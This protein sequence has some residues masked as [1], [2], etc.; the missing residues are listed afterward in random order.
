MAVKSEAREHMKSIRKLG[1]MLNLPVKFY[2]SRAEE[3]GTTVHNRRRKLIYFIRHGQGDHN[4]ACENSQY[5]CDC[6]DENPTGKCPY[7]DKTLLDSELTSKGR[8]E[9]EKLAPKTRDN[10]KDPE[11]IYVSPLRRATQ[12]ALLAFSHLVPGLK[13]S[14]RWVADEDIREHSGLH[15]C[16]HRLRAK[17]LALQFPGVDYSEITDYDPLWTEEREARIEVVYRGFM[18]ISALMRKPENVI[19]V[20]THSSFLLTLFNTVLKCDDPVLGEWFSTGELRS[21]CIS[22]EEPQLLSLPSGDI[23]KILPAYYSKL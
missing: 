2:T 23:A 6:A 7:L 4:L 21:V 8:I 10:L 11:I 3:L 18:F 12:T 13:N 17:E 1:T 19:A 16:D 5:D 9:A 20:V 14:P 15:W 22:C